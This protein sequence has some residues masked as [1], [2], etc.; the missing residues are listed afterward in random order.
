M[1]NELDALEQKLKTLYDECNV[2]DPRELFDI[3]VEF[4]RELERKGID[5]YDY[6]YWTVR[7]EQFDEMSQIRRVKEDIEQ[8]ILKVVCWAYKEHLKQHG[9]ECDHPIRWSNNHVS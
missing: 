8:L 2:A 9:Y 5:K 1:N 7:D 3:G 4:G 6:K